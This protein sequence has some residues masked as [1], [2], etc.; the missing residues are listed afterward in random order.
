MKGGW[1]KRVL[2]L[3]LAALLFGAAGRM[4]PRLAQERVDTRLTVRE[5]IKGVPPSYALADG[6]LGGFRSFLITALW[7][8]GQEKKQ[9]GQYYEMVDIYK[10][11]STL[12]PNYPSTWANMAW[13]LSYNVSAEF[14]ED[15][16]ERLYWY[17]TGINMLRNEAVRHNP[18]A[19]RLYF[20]LSWLFYNKATESVDPAF[21]LYRK[22]IATEMMRILLGPG[23]RPQLEAIAAAAR[24]YPDPALFLQRPPVRALAEELR[25]KNFELLRDSVFLTAVMPDEVKK[26]LGENANKEILAEALLLH[27][28][29]ALQGVPNLKPEV[30]LEL[31]T[32]FGDIDWRLPQAHSLYWAWLGQ[33]YYVAETPQGTDL[34]YERLIYFSLIQLA[35]KGAGLITKEGYV[36]APPD[37]AIL[38]KV[39]AYMEDLLARIK[40]QPGITGVRAGFENFLRICVFN[41]YFED[42]RINAERMRLKLIKVTGEEKKFGGTLNDFMRRELPDFIDGMMPDRAMMLLVSFC[43]RSYWYLANGDLAKFQEQTQWFESNYLRLYQDW[44]TRFEGTFHWKQQ[45]GMPTPEV[46]QAQIAANILAGNAEYSPAMLKKFEAGLQK[47]L[48]KVWQIAKDSINARNS[49]LIQPVAPD[50]A[51]PMKKE[52]AKTPSLPLP[53]IPVSGV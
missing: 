49:N 3:V 7:N 40:G 42:D 53:R 38:D 2:Y 50:G 14:N 34:R 28:V 25:K 15:P 37:T 5:T 12:E 35:H 27:A 32:R 29:Q 8:R 41:Y 52:D 51:T 48:P 24:E 9:A 11:I 26:L 4:L 36:I 30:M 33:K 10:I 1:G 17:M 46:L 23:Y 21:P 31:N 44:K 47:V 16:Q 6:L 18:R 20:E 45:F 22:Y 19:A 13:D 43:N 39:V